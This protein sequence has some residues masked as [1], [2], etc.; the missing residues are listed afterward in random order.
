MIVTSHLYFGRFTP[1]VFLCL[2]FIQGISRIESDSF[3]TLD[4]QS[5]FNQEG[6]SSPIK[7]A[8]KTLLEFSAPTIENIRTGLA[9][10]TNMKFEIKPSLINMV[11]AIQ[12]SG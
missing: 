8:E 11:Q 10:H 2:Y 1:V 9:I 6:S 5:Q 7:M 12:F 3:K 4:H